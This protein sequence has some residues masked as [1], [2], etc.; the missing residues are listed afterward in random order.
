MN[1]RHTLLTAIICC[2]ATLRCLA[3][4][5]EIPDTTAINQ[6][7]DMAWSLARVNPDSAMQMAGE[8]VRRSMARDNYAKGLMNGYLLLGIL[9]K[10]RGYYGLS[11]E[12]YLKALSIAEQEGD[13]LRVSGCLNNLGSVC[14]QQGNYE[15]AL[16]Y[17]QRSLALERQY[18]KDKEQLSIRLFN[19]GE[20]NE[21]LDCLDEAYAYYYNSLLMEEE[22]KNKE[23]IFYAR[24]GIGKVD[25]RL[26]NWVRAGMGLDK[27]YE[28][29]V[30]LQNRPGIC[31]TRIAQADLLIRIGK[32]PAAEGRLEDAISIAD[33]FGYQQLRMEALHSL[34]AAYKGEGNY[35]NAMTMLE[36]YYQ[37]REELNSA[38]VNSR[39]GELQTRYE[40]EKKEQQITRMR[41][42]ELVRTEQI[43]HERKLR[44]YLFT[45][46]GVVIALILFNVIRY[47]IR[48]SR[49]AREE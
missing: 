15:K 23:G 13:F 1:F 25:T 12:R 26:G 43:R 10:D 27:A 2:L 3:I 8:V 6:L 28:Y 11:V 31:E 36:E 7:S 44:N 17:F 35:T 49:L 34:S 22:M 18:G 37:I 16:D 47:F 33:S 41:E 45:M 42:Q 21:K 14:V 40:L 48:A 46:V 9:N 38:T 39:I 29:A 30:E 32:F 4:S 24:L 19:I 5:P 20:A